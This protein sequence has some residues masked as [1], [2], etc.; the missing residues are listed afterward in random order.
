MKGHPVFE[1]TCRALRSRVETELTEYQ[2]RRLAA[3]YYGQIRMIDEDIGRVLDELRRQNLYDDTM[4]I[5]T[6]DHG[7]HLGQYGLF[8][9]GQM[10]D[11]CCRVPLI[12][13]PAGTGRT[14]RTVSQ[15][16]NS[17]DLYGTVLDAAGDDG[18]KTPQ[19]E[20]GSL[21]E[22]LADGPEGP[23]EARSIVG[24]DRNRAVC[25][26]RRGPWKLIRLATGDSGHAVYELYDLES[27]PEETIDL[28]LIH[29]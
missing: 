22:L 20:A 28:S 9:K 25:M 2:V 24:A 4:I 16:V 8:F 6:S 18:W 27:D 15:V 10:Y 5:F 11:S 12:I 21:T 17:L 1:A 13:K 19:T 29:I 26:L 7:D 23:G 3:Q 14:G